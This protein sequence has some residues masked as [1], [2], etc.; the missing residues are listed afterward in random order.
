MLLK[1]FSKFTTTSAVN[2]VATVF[3]SG[4]MLRS[5]ITYRGAIPGG[6]RGLKPPKIRRKEAKNSPERGA[7]APPIFI[8]CWKNDTFQ[9]LQNFFVKKNF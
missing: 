1:N 4:M 8:T 2:T 5:M 7:Q 3:E 9:A 6:L